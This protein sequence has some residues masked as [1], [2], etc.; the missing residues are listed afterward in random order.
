MMRRLAELVK[1]PSRRW[2]P[3]TG[4]YGTSRGNPPVVKEEGTGNERWV[5]S[6]TTGGFMRYGFGGA[7]C[8]TAVDV[9]MEA[10]SAITG[11]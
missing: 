6:P 4:I 10:R 5:S 9:R 1:R 7:I 11:G 8:T 3:I 2:E